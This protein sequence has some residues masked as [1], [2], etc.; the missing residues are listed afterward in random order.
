MEHDFAAA[1]FLVGFGVVDGADEPVAGQA[2]AELQILDALPVGADAEAKSLGKFDL[3]GIGA[4]HR[5]VG[6]GLDRRGGEGPQP[7]KSHGAVGERGLGAADVFLLEGGD[8]GAHA[9]VE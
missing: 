8:V 5:I 4:G 3:G 2:A 7:E 1:F 9:V 6:N